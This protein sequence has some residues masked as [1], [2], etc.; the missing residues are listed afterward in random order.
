[1]NMN[2][3]TKDWKGGW[4][5]YFTDY[6][7]SFLHMV[8]GYFFSFFCGFLLGPLWIC[9]F[10]LTNFPWRNGKHTISHHMT[11]FMACITLQMVKIW[12][13]RIKSPISHVRS[14]PHI[15]HISPPRTRSVINFLVAKQVKWEKKYIK[16]ITIPSGWSPWLLILLQAL[17]NLS[18]HSPPTIFFHM[19]KLMTD[20]TFYIIHQG[21]KRAL[22]PWNLT[23]L[24]QFPLG[25]KG[26]Q[27]VGS[28]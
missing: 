23:D 1:M 19:S 22:I 3:V 16:T 5:L 20:V 9:C 24:P 26:L 15:K 14:M 27:H 8:L 25:V 18:I 28:P 6:C 13:E 12:R 2:E 7:F 4:Y 17:L 21:N 10:F 11:K